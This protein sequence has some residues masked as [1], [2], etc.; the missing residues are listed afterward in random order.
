MHMRRP[1]SPRVEPIPEVAAKAKARMAESP[2]NAINVLATMAHNK[3]ISKALGKFA[4]AVLTETTIPAR[5][6]ELAILRMGWNCQAVYEFGQ[7]TLF[8]RDAGLTEAEIYLTTR[9]LSEGA[10]SASDR[11]VLQATDDLY[12]DDCLSD[13]SWRDLSEH[14]S[15]PE[16]MEVIASAAC[17]RVVSGFLNSC[18]V[19]LDE[20]VPGWPSPVAAQA[21]ATS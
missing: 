19:Q 21:G 7:H 18:G 9:P 6:R 14:F 17:Y 15:V 8:G 4:G 13:A 1:A 12:T 5:Q 16:V 10:W 20:G 3:V 2:A 11:A